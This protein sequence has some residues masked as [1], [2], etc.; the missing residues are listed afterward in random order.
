ME[1][2]TCTKEL[3]TRDYSY[4]E[5]EK[6]CPIV[7]SAIVKIQKILQKKVGRETRVP[8]G[9]P[10]SRSDTDKRRTHGAEVRETW[11]GFKW[12]ALA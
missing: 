3:Q 4:G 7:S 11:G 1:K 5:A 2:R 10:I 12:P 6:N 9:A 8:K